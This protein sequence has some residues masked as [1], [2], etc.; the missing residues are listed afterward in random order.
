[1]DFFWEGELGHGEKNMKFLQISPFS[2]S[3][4]PLIYFFLGGGGNAWLPPCSL[5]K[6]PYFEIGW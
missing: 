4:D 1:M 5:N 6:P 3:L 2:T